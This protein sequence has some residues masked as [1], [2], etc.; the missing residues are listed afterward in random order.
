MFGFWRARD[1]NSGMTMLGG[2]F[3]I[4]RRGGGAKQSL[5]GTHSQAELGNDTV[6]DCQAALGETHSQAALGN[7]TTIFVSRRRG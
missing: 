3:W 7:D 1:E 4:C 5:A 6:L 2:G